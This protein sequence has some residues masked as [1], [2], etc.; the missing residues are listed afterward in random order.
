MSLD[1]VFG[2]EEGT[3]LVSISPLLLLACVAIAV[4]AGW[5]C[6]LVY[7]NTYNIEKS[8]RLYIPFALAG[9]LL[10]TV[11]GLPVLFSI[12]AQLFGL[13]MLALISN[14]YFKK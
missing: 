10:F 1:E 6:V 12:G 2:L 5:L 11:L 9:I 3:L 13:A 14:Y 8:V 4:L 7:R